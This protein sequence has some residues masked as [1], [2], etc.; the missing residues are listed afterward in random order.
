ML[1]QPM[2]VFDW[3]DQIGGA[4]DKKQGCAGLG[5]PVELYGISEDLLTYARL[6]VEVGRQ[7]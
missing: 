2:V 1:R 7:G 3:E 6:S 5:F 4:V